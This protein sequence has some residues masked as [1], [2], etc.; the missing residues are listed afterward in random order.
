MNKFLAE[1]YAQYSAEILRLSPL[2]VKA[3]ALGDVSPRARWQF[4]ALELAILAKERVLQIS[5]LWEQAGR[6]DHTL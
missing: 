4:A 6:L 1:L 5:S 3:A 2:V